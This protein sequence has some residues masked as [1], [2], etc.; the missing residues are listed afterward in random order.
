MFVHTDKPITLTPRDV[1]LNSMLSVRHITFHLTGSRYFGNATDASDWDFFAET[2]PDNGLAHWLSSAG[3]NLLSH[4]RY[5]DNQTVDVWRHPTGIDVQE[6]KSAKLKAS[7]QI[8]LRHLYEKGA[9]QLS[10]GHW[11]AALR[12]ASEI[13]T[14]ED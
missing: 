13:L 5:T 4:S 9:M 7:A 1:V 14:R 10:A 3:F 2:L 12:A 6:V 8:I 11:D